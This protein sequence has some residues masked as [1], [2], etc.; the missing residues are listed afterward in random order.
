MVGEEQP[1][2]YAWLCL[3]A[4]QWGTAWEGSL[5]DFSHSGPLQ[6]PIWEA[7]LGQL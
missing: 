1:T 5:I 7:T 4:Y 6:G 3:G 2:N